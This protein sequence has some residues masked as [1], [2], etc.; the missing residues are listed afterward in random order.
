MGVV[1]KKYSHTFSINITLRNC[2]LEET[3]E[4]VDFSENYK[5]LPVAVELVFLMCD[6]LASCG[7]RC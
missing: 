7:L 1:R 6:I 5:E 4:T 2:I 3:L